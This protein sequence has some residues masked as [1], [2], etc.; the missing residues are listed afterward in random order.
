M[1]SSLYLIRLTERESPKTAYRRF[2]NEEVVSEIN[3]LNIF[4]EDEGGNRED[5]ICQGWAKEYFK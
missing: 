4:L 3:L 2:I 1:V 5:Y